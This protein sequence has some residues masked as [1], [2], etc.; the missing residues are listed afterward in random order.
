V[1][2]AIRGRLV[3]NSLP[4]ALD[5]AVRGLGITRVPSALADGA[6]GSGALVELLPAHVPP[7]AP[8]YLVYPSGTQTTPRVHAFLAIVKRSLVAIGASLVGRA[9]PALTS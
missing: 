4:L 5:A 7:A 2:V 6:I 9:E 1:H 3:V 8:L